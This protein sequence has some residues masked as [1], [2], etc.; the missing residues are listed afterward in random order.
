MHEYMHDPALCVN[1]LLSFRKALSHFSSLSRL[2]G[3]K[4]VYLDTNLMNLKQLVSKVRMFIY[5]TF[6]PV[7]PFN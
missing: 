1:Q 6:L 5:V 3:S 4:N 2:L 7:W